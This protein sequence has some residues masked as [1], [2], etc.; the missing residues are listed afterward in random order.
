[1]CSIDM[2]V[3]LFGKFGC[4]RQYRSYISMSESISS[5]YS[6][7]CMTWLSSSSLNRSILRLASRA[8]RSSDCEI[9]SVNSLES[10]STF[11]MISV[12]RDFFSVLQAQKPCE[13][14]I[15]V[16]TP[17]IDKIMVVRLSMIC[18]QKTRAGSQR[19]ILLSTS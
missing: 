2:T 15:A 14:K 3:L 17:I 6:F 1:M 10:S 4:S 19:W 9:C 16:N 18:L 13:L 8:D 12:E 5:K 11:S 7:E